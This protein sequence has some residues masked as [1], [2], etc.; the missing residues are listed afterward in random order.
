[1]VQIKWTNFALQN[2][3]D[4]GDYIEHDSSRSASIVVSNLFDAV[5]ILETFPFCGR[6][7]P[8]FNNEYIRELI[9]LRYR[10]VYYVLNEDR[11][12]ILTVYHS[13]QLLTEL[14]ALYNNNEL[15]P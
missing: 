9:R 5:N 8:E 1:M 11:I 10:I 2:L 7:V 13:A 3:N 4:I 12:D 14:P 15:S 6:I